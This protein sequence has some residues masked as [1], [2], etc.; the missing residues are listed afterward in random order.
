MTPEKEIFLDIDTSFYSKVKMG[1]GS[2]V[3][4]KGKDNVGVET[5][6]GLKKI[7]KVLFVPELDQNL[8]NIGQLMEYNYVLHFEGRTCIV[9]DKG[10]EKLVVAKVKIAPN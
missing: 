8:L 5:K 4:V 2:V 9:Y 7:R 6:R 1:N 10:R 3:Y